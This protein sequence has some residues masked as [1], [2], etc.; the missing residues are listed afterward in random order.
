MR[1]FFL[2]RDPVD[3]AVAVTFSVDGIALESDETA[4]LEL[5]LSSETAPALAGEGIFFCRTIKLRIMDSDGM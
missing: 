4:M 5:K 2:H 1:V 3:V